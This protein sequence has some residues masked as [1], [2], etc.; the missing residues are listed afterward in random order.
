MIVAPLAPAAVAGAPGLTV[1]QARHDA[2]PVGRA[3][4][5]EHVP[6]LQS[7]QVREAGLVDTPSLQGDPG[8]LQHVGII[9]A[10]YALTRVWGHVVALLAAVVAGLLVLTPIGLSALAWHGALALAL[11]A[12]VFAL[13]ARTLD[14]PARA[15]AVGAAVGVLKVEGAG[16]GIDGKHTPSKEE[17]SR[18]VVEFALKQL[19]A[20]R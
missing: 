1:P 8:L 16:H 18:A 17:I 19:A 14:A 6:T 10:I 15:W 11:W 20:E 4:P 5:G 2:P 7:E 12:L 13:R 9:T 3:A